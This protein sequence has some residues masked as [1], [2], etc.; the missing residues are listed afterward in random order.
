MRLTKI[1][2][3]LRRLLW[4]FAEW[5]AFHSRYGLV[6]AVAYISTGHSQR[7]WSWSRG[8]SMLSD[9]SEPRK[10]S[11]YKL[12]PS[13]QLTLVRYYVSRAHFITGSDDVS[14]Q[15]RR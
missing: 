11:V 14:K 9:S 6:A 1:L 7:Q 12:T 2:R 8:A 10:Y 3:K 13:V 5:R 4:R 15:V